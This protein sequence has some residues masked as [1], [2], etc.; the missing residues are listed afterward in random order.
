MMYVLLQY[1]LYIIYGITCLSLLGVTEL[2]R[3]EKGLW[4]S[5]NRRGETQKRRDGITIAIAGSCLSLRGGFL[6]LF[7]PSV[8]P[9]TACSIRALQI[10]PAV[11]RQSRPIPFWRSRPQSLTGKEEIWSEWSL[12][13][14]SSSSNCCSSHV[15]MYMLWVK[16]IDDNGTCR[17]PLSNDARMPWKRNEE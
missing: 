11:S 9:E 5:R 7:P 2:K 10:V 14:S 13:D 12:G 8:N 1:V 3:G 4:P 16:S 17:S 15:C 6:L